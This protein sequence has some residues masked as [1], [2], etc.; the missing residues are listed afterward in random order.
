ME[1]LTSKQDLILKEIKKYMAK[2]GYPPTVR[3]LCKLADLKSTATIQSH[4]DNLQ[5]KGYIRKDKEKNRTIELLVPN[6]YEDKS[7]NVVS[8][9]LLGKVTAGSPIEA[10]EA[11]F[12]YHSI[13]CGIC[14][15]L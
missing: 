11:W 10:I 14:G 2:R 4:L 5:E 1:K 9:P 7:D 12:N 3:E 15:N 6:E 8:I 13:S